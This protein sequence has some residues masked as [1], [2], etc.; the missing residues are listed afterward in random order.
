MTSL[1]NQPISAQ[2]HAPHLAARG[3][4]EELGAEACASTGL[5][6]CSRSASS[7]FG[8]SQ[9]VTVLL[10]HVHRPAEDHHRV[11]SE[12]IGRRLPTLADQPFLDLRARLAQSLG[13]DAGGGVAL[14]DDRKDAHGAQ[15]ARARGA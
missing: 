10:V 13:E 9:G 6:P 2:V 11:V 14:V 4:A 1:P 8:S 5:P 3:R 15:S 12:G 7:L